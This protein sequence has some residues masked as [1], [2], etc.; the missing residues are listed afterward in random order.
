MLRVNVPF[1]D[2]CLV[3]EFRNYDFFLIVLETKG[4]NP[5]TVHSLGIVVSE[6]GGSG[7]R[8]SSLVERI[9]KIRNI[10]M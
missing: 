9:Q 2:I 10:P 6:L 5:L 8:R 1:R 3:L 4:A 7:K